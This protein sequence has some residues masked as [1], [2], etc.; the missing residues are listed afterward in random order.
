MK[1][2]AL[3]IWKYY[4]APDVWLLSELFSTSFKPDDLIIVEVDRG[5]DIAQ[6]IH[7]S[8]SDEEVLAQILKLLI[9]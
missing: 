7:L 2:T 4:F 1:K 5:E 8:V 3:N 9:L 6:V